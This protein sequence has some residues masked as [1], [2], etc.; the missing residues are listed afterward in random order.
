MR[1]GRRSW[2]TGPTDR[3]SVTYIRVGLGQITGC[4]LEVSEEVGV[5][6]FDVIVIVS[7]LSSFLIVSVIISC[8]CLLAVGDVDVFA[9]G[10]AP[11][12]S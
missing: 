6:E 5:L 9:R 11:N 3:P 10:V 8:F 1:S 12:V 2:L 7:L 4:V